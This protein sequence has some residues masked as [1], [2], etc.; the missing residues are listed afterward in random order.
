MLSLK[1]LFKP[2]FAGRKPL[3]EFQ[4][5]WFVSKPL[6]FFVFFKIDEK[7]ENDSAQ[8]NLSFY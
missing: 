8:I 7:K 3:D 4:E 1:S 6:A 2:L 5:C